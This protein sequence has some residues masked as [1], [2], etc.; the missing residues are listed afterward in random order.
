MTTLSQITSMWMWIWIGPVL[1]GLFARSFWVSALLFV[2]NAAVVALLV[3]APEL[4]SA[5]L[6]VLYAIALGLVV[7]SRRRA[8]RAVDPNIDRLLA[9]VQ[10]LNSKRSDY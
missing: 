3:E 1:L 10:Q 2:L 8:R 9:E 4:G 7:V 5:A 6:A